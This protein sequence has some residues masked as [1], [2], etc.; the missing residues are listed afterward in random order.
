MSTFHLAIPIADVESTEKFYTQVLGATTGRRYRD[1]V[2]FRFFDHQLVCHVSP[3]DL[4]HEPSMYPRH[5]GLIF[6]EKADFD[7]LYDRCQKAE[8]DFFR[9]RFV[10]WPDLPEQHETFFVVDPSKNLLEF[11]FYYNKDSIF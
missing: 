2:I 4:P 6:H 10:R 11:K 7:D 1:R 9:D 3:D 8:C 5:F